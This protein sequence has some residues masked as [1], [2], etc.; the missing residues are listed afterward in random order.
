M[1]RTCLKCHA[2]FADKEPVKHGLHQACFSALFETNVSDEFENVTARHSESFEPTSN[3]N[4]DGDLGSFFHG[5]FKKYSA[6]L[7]KFEYIL[8][9]KDEK[10]A[11][12]LPDVEFLSNL[13]A[14]KI[15]LPVPWFTLIDFFENRTFITR[16]FVLEKPTAL[17]LVHIYHYIK[18]DEPYSCETILNII[19]NHSQRQ[20]DIN[21]FI[22]MCLFDAL[23]GNHD[24]HGRNIAIL[25]SGSKSYLAPIYDN[26]SFLGL[27]TGNML[28]A[29]FDPKCRIATS[30]TDS[31]TLKEYIQEFI[32]LGCSKDVHKFKKNVHL[33]DI[34]ALIENSTCRPLMKQAIEKLITKRYGDMQNVLL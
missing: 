32:R 27:E 29:Q 8:K 19:K 12:E 2:V 3:S 25:T 18:T 17:N 5:K 24:R 34:V 21:T 22:H 23:I 33:K 20:K 11:P 26:P 16:N 28:K 14:E 10:E 1:K 6:K 15:G 4:G 31:P 9:V 7:G 13:M 30:K